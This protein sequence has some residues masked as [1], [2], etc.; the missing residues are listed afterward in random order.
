MGEVR[1]H[2]AEPELT[3]NVDVVDEAACTAQEPIVL[4]TENRS[5][6]VTLGHGH[7]VGW[8]AVSCTRSAATR[9]ALTMLW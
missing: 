5:T 7:A 3:R 4:E 9:T 6:D 8:P 2:D 1:P